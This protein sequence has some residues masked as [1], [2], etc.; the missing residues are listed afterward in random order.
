MEPVASDE[1]QPT[2]EEKEPTT[3]QH[4]INRTAVIVGGVGVAALLFM[5]WR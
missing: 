3:T 5:T 1:T 4:E 2:P